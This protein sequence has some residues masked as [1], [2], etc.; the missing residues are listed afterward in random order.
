MIDE[1]RR[2]AYLGA[3]Q[4]VSWLP[5]V[6]LPFAAPS[7]PELLETPEPATPLRTDPEPGGVPEM[8]SRPRP[9]E[10]AKIEVP[11]P[12]ARVEAPAVRE[13][14]VEPA[15][16][17]AASLPPPRFALQLLRAGRCALLVELPTGE[18]F[19]SRDPGYL[20]LRDLLRAAGL[21]DSPRT[22]GEPVRWPLFRG[23]NLDQGPQAA[24]EYVQTFVAARLEEEGDC[25]CL[26]LVGLP[27]LRFAAA[28]EA[29]ACLR[30]LQVEGLPPLW[31]L[32]GLETLMEEP[33]RKAE[34]WRAMR[35]V[36]MRWMSANE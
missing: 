21:A 28:V 3:M 16:P 23:G 25:A 10:R 2:R 19:Q 1:A 7:R 30:E 26:W 17:K 34:L 14:I 27:A 35:R 4:V 5:R 24:L 29:D 15:A 36:R 32:P 9:V 6:A 31:A 33:A 18:P 8:P 22:L 13:A 12:V 11:R 20:L